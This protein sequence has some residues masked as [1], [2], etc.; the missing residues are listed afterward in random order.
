M[1][2]VFLLLAWFQPVELWAQSPGDSSTLIG[3][4]VIGNEKAPQ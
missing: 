4:Y 3:R 2:I 1:S